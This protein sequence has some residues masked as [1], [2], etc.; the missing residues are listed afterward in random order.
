QSEHLLVKDVYLRGNSSTGKKV[1]LELTEFSVIGPNTRIIIQKG[2]KEV[3]GAMPTV[4]TYRGKVIGDP[5]THVVLCLTNDKVSGMIRFNGREQYTIGYDNT[6]SVAYITVTNALAGVVNTGECAMDNEKLYD[7]TNSLQKFAAV[8]NTK[9]N[10]S[11]MPQ[12]ATKSATIAFDADKQCYDFFGDETSLTD[13]LVARLAVISSVYEAELDVALQL[14]RFKIYTTPDP[15]SGTS[16]QPLLTSFTNYWSSNNSGVDRT[17]AHLISKK[18]PGGGAAGLAWLSGLC[19]KDIGYAVTSIMGSTSFPSVDESVIAHEIGHNFGSAHTHNCQAYPP[20]GIDHCVQADGG[21]NWTPVQITGSIMSYCN[22]KDFSFDTPNDHRVIETIKSNIDGAICLGSVAGIETIPG[23]VAFAG[24]TAIHNKKDSTF[25]GLIRSV[26]TVPL[27]ISNL[28]IDPGTD[29]EF[30]LKSPKT[31]PITIQPNNTSNVTIT[32]QPKYG[33]E[34][35][36]QLYI[37][38]NGAGSPSVVDITGT[39]AAPMIEEK[40]VGLDYGQITFKKRIDTQFVYLQNIGDAPLTIYRKY[41]E[42]INP[43][44]WTIMTDTNKETVGIN[45][46][47]F[48]KIRFKPF[49]IGYSSAYFTYTHDAGTEPSYVSLDADIVAFDTA[50]ISV[51]NDLHTAGI[52][53]NISP[54][55]SNAKVTVDISIPEALVGK[56]VTLTIVDMLGKTVTSLYDGKLSASSSQYSWQPEATIADGVYTLIATINGKNYTKQIVRMK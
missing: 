39:G 13:Y 28:V 54:N 48:V 27:V 12:A 23:E 11:Q 46:S 41:I 52:T 3:E 44:D 18:V 9:K 4:K 24:K 53:M 42:G 36:G 55:P 15:Y 21:C 45:R 1:D 6:P 37:Y 30:V 33:A 51:G 26:G 38:H 50:Q 8:K 35:T 32:F 56:E 17:L 14:G 49:A 10:P 5:N 25:T 2:D 43:D 31:F 22:N 29:T 20:D 40:F 19:R 7:P 16:L 47:T 34:R